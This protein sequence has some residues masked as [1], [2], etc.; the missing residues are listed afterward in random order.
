M[1]IAEKTVV[2]I[3]YTLRDGSATGEVI[4]VVNHHEPFLFLFGAGQLLPQ[5]EEQLMGLKVGDSFEFLLEGDEAYGPYQEDAIVALPLNT[6]MVDGSLDMEM[7]QVGNMLPMQN[8]DGEYFEGVI[9]AVD[10]NS[11]TMDFNHP[12]AGVDLHFKGSVVDVRPASLEELAHGH[13][14]GPGGHHHH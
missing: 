6:F 9:A 10:D 3:T 8:A 13:A 2:S 14:H 11:V 5:F 7:L 12:M 4:E 1:N